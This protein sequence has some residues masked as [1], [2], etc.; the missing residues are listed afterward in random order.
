MK[1]NTDPTFVG[2][3]ALKNIHAQQVTDFESWAARGDWERFHYSHYDWWAFP[4]SRSSAYGMKYVVFEGEI[5]ELRK[6]AAFVEKYQAGVRLVAASWGWDLLGC[7]YI[8]HPQAGQCWHD[9][10]VRLFKAA[11]SVKLFGYDETFASLKIYALDLMQM[12]KKMEYNGKDL[13]WL[14]TEL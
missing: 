11:Q 13:S 8:D 2:I 12:G 1:F 5:A 14:F 3:E 7:R 6:D 10:P 9:W 4:I